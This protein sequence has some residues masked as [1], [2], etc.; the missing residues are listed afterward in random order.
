MIVNVSGDAIDVR[1]WCHACKPTEKPAN[2]SG[3]FQAL[4]CGAEGLEPGQQPLPVVCEY[5]DSQAEVMYFALS[6]WQ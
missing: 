2:W 1:L 6:S 3:K 4:M 5:C